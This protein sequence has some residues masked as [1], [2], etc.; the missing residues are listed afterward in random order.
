MQGGDPSPDG[1][2]MQMNPM[3][4]QM[5][6]MAAQMNAMGGQMN[7]MAAQMMMMGGMMPGM[8][9]GMPG[10][11]Q[12]PQGRGRAWRIDFPFPLSLFVLKKSQQAHRPCTKILYVWTSTSAPAQGLAV[13]LG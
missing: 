12:L 1:N 7:P 4:G 13:F 9:G 11:A 6:P 5:N 8:M 3:G 10:M 2:G